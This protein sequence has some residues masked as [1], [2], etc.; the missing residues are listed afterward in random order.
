MTL[1]ETL[2]EICEGYNI[3]K[4]EKLEQFAKENAKLRD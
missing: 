1:K 3:P 4:K 2:N